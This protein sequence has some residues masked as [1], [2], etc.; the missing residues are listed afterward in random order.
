[1]D[2][3]KIGFSFHA[4]APSAEAAPPRDDPAVCAGKFPRSRKFAG[5]HA[6]VF[7]T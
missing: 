3:G 1:M 6:I 4:G 2:S 5:K 7:K